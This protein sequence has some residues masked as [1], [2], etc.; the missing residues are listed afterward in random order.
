MNLKGPL[1]ANNNPTNKR[2]RIHCQPPQVYK[3]M[4]ATK[5][6]CWNFLVVLL[7]QTIGKLPARGLY[8]TR[9]QT[10]AISPSLFNGLAFTGWQ[11]FA[12]KPPNFRALVELHILNWLHRAY[13]ACQ[14]SVAGS[15]NELIHVLWRRRQVSLY[16]AVAC[17]APPASSPLLAVNAAQPA[18]AS[19]RCP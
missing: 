9:W 12:A 19:N 11:S 2:L 13:S 4:L 3:M 18:R 8:M 10:S 5:Y 15:L 1:T 16:E 7:F 17:S 14:L 6:Q